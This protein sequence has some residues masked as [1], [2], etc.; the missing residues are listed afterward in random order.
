MSN[1]NDP[2]GKVVLL[3]EAGNKLN[4]FV[5]CPAYVLRKWLIPNEKKFR[6]PK[7]KSLLMVENLIYENVDPE[8]DWYT[9]DYV[10]VR[11]SHG[12]DCRH[13]YIR[14]ARI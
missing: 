14:V 2:N 8:I 12:N 4:N 7:D 13:P 11:F 1:K 6:Y 10:K 9:L 5:Q 3:T